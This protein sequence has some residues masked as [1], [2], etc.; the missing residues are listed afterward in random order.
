MIKTASD[1]LK[2]FSD[3]ERE[4]LDAEKIMHGPTIGAMY[5]GLT[6]EMLDTV[7][8]QELNLRIVEGF[9][10]CGEKQS[11]QL[12]CMLVMGEGEKIPKTTSYR[13]PVQDVI[14]VLEVK[15]TLTADDLSDSY[16]HLRG[17]LNLFHDH[18]SGARRAPGPSRYRID[19]PRRIFAQITGVVPPAHE[20]VSS[21]PFDLQ[22]IYYAIIVEYI[23]PIRIM[24]GHHGWK[25]E[26]TL[27]DNFVKL[28]QD[29]QSSPRGMGVGSFPQLVIGGEYSLVKANGF[30][31]V[32]SLI[33]GTWPFFAST[34]CNPLRLMLELIFSKI[35]FMFGTDLAHDNDLEQEALT[36]FLRAKAVQVGDH[37]GWGYTYD[38]IE[39]RSLTERGGTFIWRPAEISSAQAAI[40]HA[41]CNGEDVDVTEEAFRLV[42]E[43]EGGT[44]E[45]F[46]EALVSTQLIARDGDR[47][48]LTTT[49]CAVV[50]APDGKFYAAE[51]NTGQLMPWLSSTFPRSP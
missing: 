49:G 18:I 12:D 1:L 45:A 13:W 25:K 50:A 32:T 30:P 16:D 48:E 31:Y 34:R 43:R 47:L 9:A 7:I 21:L 17:V 19:V 44:T 28:I 46:I 14:A 26:R 41:L 11:G 23:S 33:D 4:L 24:I 15:K 36:S 2:A 22:M 37:A 51:N 38:L 40:F 35:D 39:E 42:A 27:R 6:R 8:P 5:E 3:R 20:S 10:C 29:R